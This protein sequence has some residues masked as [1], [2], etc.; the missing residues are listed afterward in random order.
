MEKEEFREKLMR[1]GVLR[2]SGAVLTPLTGGVSSEIYYIKDGDREFVAKRALG[3]LKVAETWT[4]DRSRNRH[5]VAYLKLVREIR[6]D[7]VPE[8]YADFPSGGYFTMEYFDSRYRC[9]KDLLLRG[10]SDP[11][12]AGQSGRLLGQIHAATWGDESLRRQF[13]HTVLF[14]DLRLD[15]Y[16]VTTARRHEPFADLLMA[17]AARIRE[18]RQCLVHGDFSP[19]NLLVGKDR[20]IVLD[21]EVAWYGDAAFD[22]AFL[23]NHLMIKALHLPAYREIYG[24]MARH[25]WGSYIDE[26]GRKRGPEL[27]TTVARLLPM[28][29][30]ARVDGKSPVEYL[31]EGNQ[32]KIREF[33]TTALPEPH[34][35]LGG[36]IAGWLDYLTFSIDD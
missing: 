21:C 29:M 16:L 15:P 28:L 34:E 19:K 23:L 4:A 17:E 7:A 3:Q 18:S 22:V 8:V 36:L 20:L 33:V 13:D 24:E 6:P 26:L 25:A 1:D 30:L 5:E 27:E 12:T 31:D 2:D 14:D 11:S 35:N 9:W 10:E 32:Q